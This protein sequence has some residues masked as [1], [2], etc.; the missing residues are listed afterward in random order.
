MAYRCSVCG[1]VHHDRPAYAFISPD[2]YHLLS[3]DEQVSMAK[4]SEDWCV[5]EHDT[6]S[7]Y[8][9]RAILRLPIHDT[10]DTFEY[11]VWVSLSEKNFVYYMD[12]FNEDIE[13][14][15]FFGYLCNQIP[16]YE[17]TLLIKTNVVCGGK[18]QRPEV[19]LHKDQGD[20]L[21][22]NDFFYGITPEE[23]DR[24]THLLLY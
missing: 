20:H 4:L 11:G 5:I 7:D 10:D 24:R 19:F 18:G 14:T 12:N 3:Q 16:G 17:N 22:V 21:F 1:E 8:F 15:T 2:Y 9:V 13:G 23:A 6:Q